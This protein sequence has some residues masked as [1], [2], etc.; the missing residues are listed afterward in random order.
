MRF[1][2]RA[3]TIRGKS[4]DVK[5]YDARMLRERMRSCFAMRDWKVGNTNRAEKLVVLACISVH[6]RSFVIKL[7]G[8]SLEY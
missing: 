2:M 6:F 5:L 8:L 4:R 1:L 7:G 3:R